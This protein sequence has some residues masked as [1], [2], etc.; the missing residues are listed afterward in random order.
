MSL[1]S[2]HPTVRQWFQRD[3]GAP[4]RPQVEGWPRIQAGEHVLIAAPTGTGK[5]MAAFLSAIDALL[6]QGDELPDE[7]QILYV[8]PLRALSNDVQ[9]NLSGPLAALREMD[10]TLPGVRVLART[11]DTTQAERAGMKRRAPHV[12][13]TTPESLYV[14]LTSAS[15]RAMLGTVRTVIVDEVHALARDKRGSHLALSLERLSDLCH[16]T[17]GREV[18]RIGLSATQ[19]PLSDVARLLVGEGRACAIVDAGHLRDLD[20][21]VVVPDSPLTAVCSHEQWRELYAKM[22]A[23]IRAHRVTLVFVNTRKLAERLGARLTE[24]LGV[25]AVA[26]HHGSL[27]KE[28]RLDAEQRLKRGELRALVATAS[29]ELGIDIGDVDLVMQVGGVRTIATFLQRVGRAGHGIQR[30]PKGRAFPLTLDEAVEAAAVLS[31]VRRRVLDVTPRAPAA[32]DILAQQI[33][34]A[35]AAADA[36][37]GWK[38]A[39]LFAC[40]VR[41][42]PYRDVRREDFEAL[43]ALHANGRN[44][45]LHRDAVGRRVMATKRARIPA[46]TSGGAIPDNADY[47]VVQ[48][49]AGTFVGTLNEDFAIESNAGD[50][51]QLGNTSWRVLKIERGTVRVA[52]AEGTPPTVPFWLGE[53]PARSAELSAEV[54]R[55]RE[56][57]LD[58]DWL[59]RETGMALAAAEQVVAYLDAGRAALGATPSEHC[60]VLERFFDESGGMQLVVHAPFGG[61]VNKALGLAL[62]KRVCR[63]FGFELQAAATEEAIVLSLGPQH[64]FD[65]RE[66]FDWLRSATARDVLIQALLPAPMFTTRWRW[67]VGRSLM[68]PRTQGGKFVAP[69]ILRMRAEDLLAQAFPAAIAC[70]ETLPPGDIEVPLEHPI[71]RQT[72]E[73]CLHE[74]LDVDGMIEV[75]RG[76][77]DGRI[78]KHAIDTT[79]PSPFAHGILNAQVYAFLDDAPLEERRTQAVRTRHVLNARTAD[80]IGVLDVDAIDRVRDEAWPT[81]RTA[82]EAHEALTWMGFATDAESRAWGAAIDELASAGRAVAVD[83]PRERRWFAVEAPRAGKDVLRGR[84]EALGPVFADDRLLVEFAG[85]IAELELEGVAMRARFPVRGETTGRDGWCLRRLLSRIHRY[86]LDRLRREIQP[87]SSADFLHF[88]AAWQHVGGEHRLEGPRGVLA[89][90]EQLA[91]FQA[92]ADAWERHILPERVR[93]YRSGWLDELAFTGEV[94]WGRLWGSS[95]GVARTTPV[96]LLPRAQLDAWTRLCTLGDASDLSGEAADVL[97]ILSQRGPQFLSDLGRASGMLPARLDDALALLVGRGLATCDAFA[98]WRAVLLRNDPRVRRARNPPPAAGRW[99]TFRPSGDATS[100]RSPDAHFDDELVELAARTLLARTGVVFKN[101][102]AREKLPVPWRDVLR[103][104]RRLEARGEIHGGRFVDGFSGEQFALPEAVRRMRAL[105]RSPHC[106]PVRVDAADPLNY[107]GILTPDARIAS[108]ARQRVDVFPAAS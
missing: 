44:A 23:L 57:C 65:L 3:L 47:R 106:E 22:A 102:V 95:D 17:T 82:E 53:A 99:S 77:E 98:G 46:L 78:A 42:F 49:P 36:D 73:D 79:E 29:L 4:T 92:P 105:R 7:T 2:F 91:A 90:V 59:V 81:P 40:L 12:L 37:Q 103:C 64:S 26:C 108:N 20:I 50:I 72:I 32:L 94:A 30:T 21:D 15:G 84:L 85:E 51:F 75:L 68:L 55:I 5:T 18:Q 61:R 96:T 27:S 101:T 62:R 107:A 24:E 71:V 14:L 60:I 28:R 39:E 52:D 67:N 11:G 41:A 56:E 70:G 43:V 88:L 8:S 25:G 16:A 45:L 38:E 1:E 93:G 10:P 80:D 104:F 9:K 89:V 19:K 13:V 86:T 33:V 87:V 58:V 66:V 83:T 74:A 97:A 6:R 54:T 76:L 35:C 48:E 100:E 69:Q 31:A 63:S 34:A